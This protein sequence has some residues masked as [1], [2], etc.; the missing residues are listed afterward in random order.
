[1]FE[2]PQWRAVAEYRSGEFDAS[3]ATLAPLQTVDALYNRGNAL[4]RTGALEAAIDA[5]DRTLEL[6]PEHAD[7]AHNRALLEDLLEQQQNEQQ[8]SQQSA[9]DEGDEQNQAQGQDEGEGSSEEQGESSA[10]NRSGDGEPSQSEGERS[11]GDEE[12]EPS[13]QQAD[14][15]GEPERGEGE[16]RDEDGE[17]P[18][19]EQAAAGTE[20]VEQWASDQA[21]EQ[22]LRRIPQDPGGLLRR[23]FLYQYQRLGVDQDGNYVWPG[24]EAQPW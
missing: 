5:Y 7:A 14:A 15:E 1:M 20:D 2:D 23:K 8:Q 9:A 12:S 6:D 21:A 4:A 19:P 16:P 3:A 18:L 22:W 24:D 11:A 17:R 13:E 10:D